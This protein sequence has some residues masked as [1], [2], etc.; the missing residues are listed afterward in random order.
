MT[1]EYNSI[2]GIIPEGWAGMKTRFYM[3][4]LKHQNH[5]KEKNQLEEQNQLIR[6]V[7]APHF[8]YKCRLIIN[9]IYAEKWTLK[10]CHNI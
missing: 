4:W 3:M 10:F 2:A 7:N 9:I 8:L 5:Q 1:T 6:N